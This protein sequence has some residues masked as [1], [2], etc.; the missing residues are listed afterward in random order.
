MT[1]PTTGEQRIIPLANLQPSPFNPR[2]TFDQAKL[3]ELT[4]SIRTHG[5]LQPILVRPNGAPD[6]FEIVAGERRY[7]AATAASLETIPATI[8]ELTDAQALEL[9]VIENLQRDDLHE[10]EE[11]E[12]YERLMQCE[13]TDGTTYTV[14]EIAA[15]VGKSKS[16]VYGRLKLTALGPSG[17]KAFHEG[18]LDASR[19]LLLARIPVVELQDKALCEILRV[20]NLEKLA[21]EDREDLH[22]MSYRAALEHIQWEYTLRLKEAPFKTT[23]AELVPAAG[24]CTT[25]PK[26]SGNQPELFADLESADVCTDPKCFGQKRDAYLEQVTAKAAGKGKNVVSPK[27][28]G[29]VQLDATAKS[30]PKY[31]TYRAILGNAVE[32]VLMPRITH[33]NKTE[34]I[35]VVKKADIATLLAEKLAKA[36]EASPG[37]WNE[38]YELTR[39]IG[40]EYRKRLFTHICAAVPT[41]PGA[42]ELRLLVENE[43]HADPEHEL[44]ADLFLPQ[45]GGKKSPGGAQAR[46]KAAL[47][48][49][50]EAAL[51]RLLVALVL[52]REVTDWGD[53]DQLVEFAAVYKIDPK[54]IEKAVKA[55]LT[56]APKEKE[57]KGK[58]KRQAAEAEA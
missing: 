10:L 25:C 41:S 27:A 6:H 2:K 5:V 42:Q 56:P 22:P 7:R 40:A 8:R 44:V 18:L 48:K 9:Q 21:A 47:P 54:A 35:E 19:A 16:Y 37:R 14:D 17:R 58:K 33:D 12:G 15:K 24:A 30:D 46:I 39:K 11:A 53:D 26:R 31:R 13:R 4:E 51:L 32:P 55:E 38:D 3:D 43:I 23:D 29:Y 52:S 36:R 34:F 20:L 57:A 50:D 28:K 49:L 1:S 45:A